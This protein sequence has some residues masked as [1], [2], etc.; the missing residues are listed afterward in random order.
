[1]AAKIAARRHVFNEE[2]CNARDFE[3]SAIIG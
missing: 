1:M 2:G 3:E